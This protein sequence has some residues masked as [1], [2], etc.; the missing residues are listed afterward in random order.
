MG[1][2]PIPFTAIVEYTKM[3]EVEDLEEFIYIIRKMDSK[4]MELDGKSNNN[5]KH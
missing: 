4:L 1:N 5:Q 3:I 2:S